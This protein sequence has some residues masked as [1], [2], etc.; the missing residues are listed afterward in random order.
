MASFCP[1]ILLL[2]F[3]N[4]PLLS[5]A[6]DRRLNS[7][8]SSSSSSSSIS[9]SPA[10]LTNPPAM[11]PYQELSPDISPLLPSPGGVVPTPT[12]ISVPTI[13][14]NPSP[15]NPD[16]PGPGSAFPPFGSLPTA[17]SMAPRILLGQFKL[18]LYAAAF[19]SCHHLLRV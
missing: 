2:L 17:S 13:P 9:A 8:T 16:A 18:S 1:L 19:W 14:S 12:G 7:Q 3:M 6:S 10:L 11:S 4:S 5:I 15:P